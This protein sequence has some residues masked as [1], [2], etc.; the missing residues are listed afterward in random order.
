V[1]VSKFLNLA[2]SLLPEETS[3]AALVAG[4]V[5]ESSSTEL[6]GVDG[7]ELVSQGWF[8]G[9]GLPR[10]Q[11]GVCW[12]CCWGLGLGGGGLPHALPLPPDAV[13]A[14]VGGAS[15]SQPPE[16][17]GKNSK[18]T[19]NASSEENDGNAGGGCRDGGEL[20]KADGGRAGKEGGLVRVAGEFG[21]DVGPVIAA[22]DA[23]LAI[24]CI[25]TSLK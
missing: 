20:S 10:S 9:E 5:S 1:L 17:D 14:A 23:G 4:R 8:L 11:L 2:E 3:T 16:L 12:D 25:S 6:N 7:C 22:A 24:L 13:D 21:D 18:S 19:P 15:N